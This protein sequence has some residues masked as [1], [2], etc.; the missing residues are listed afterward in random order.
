MVRASVTH[1]APDNLQVNR[2]KGK[3]FIKVLV[4]FSRRSVCTM[5]GA[6]PLNT[7]LIMF[8]G[9]RSSILTL[10][11]ETVELLVSELQDDP[12]SSSDSSLIVAEGRARPLIKRLNMALRHY[13]GINRLF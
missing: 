7:G 10:W 13:S 11:S 1:E 4:L 2:S 8:D 6:E 3:V 5:S 12:E 9:G